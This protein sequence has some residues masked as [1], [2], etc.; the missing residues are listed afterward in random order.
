VGALYHFKVRKRH[1]S[2]GAKTKKGGNGACLQRHLHQG[3]QQKSAVAE[4]S[5]RQD[6]GRNR[7]PYRKPSER[8]GERP[9][10]KKKKK[11]GAGF[12]CELSGRGEKSKSQSN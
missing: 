5:T 8:E 12:L 3:A 11:S 9:R 7:S 10:D 1:R 6:E 4:A 2:S